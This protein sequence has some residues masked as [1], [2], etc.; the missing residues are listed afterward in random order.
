M[1]MLRYSCNMSSEI[2]RPL[3]AGIERAVSILRTGG[4][5]TFE[6]CEGGE[7]HPFPEPTV[8]FHGDGSEG[9]RA[10]A[11][12]QQNGLQVDQLRRYYQVQN[13]EPTGPYWEITFVKGALTTCPRC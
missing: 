2:E 4:V 11:I 12:A 3:D 8:R 10:L 7:G 6:S 1:S 13:G 9:F 5:E